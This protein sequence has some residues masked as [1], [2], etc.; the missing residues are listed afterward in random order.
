LVALAFPDLQPFDLI[1]DVVSGAAVSLE[2]FAK[3]ALLGIVYTS[4]YL[5]FAWAS[6]S[7]KEL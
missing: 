3:T 7:G 5:F 1:D 4:V 6:F 2:L